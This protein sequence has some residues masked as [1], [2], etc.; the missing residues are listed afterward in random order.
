[1]SIYEDAMRR[2]Q[3]VSGLLEQSSIR[4][5]VDRLH[6]TLGVELVDALT[7]YSSVLDVFDEVVSWREMVLSGMRTPLA[8]SDVESSVVSMGRQSILAMLFRQDEE[9]LEQI[10]TS[11]LQ[12]RSVDHI[13]VKPRL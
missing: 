13:S 4:S 12:I 11:I 2:I 3:L 7:R 5:A 6:T 10:Y 1:M 8:Y 9:E